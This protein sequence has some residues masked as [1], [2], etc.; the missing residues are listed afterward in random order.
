[1]SLQTETA[2]WT[3]VERGTLSLAKDCSGRH[4]SELKRRWW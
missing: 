3:F 4:G 2:C 1:M